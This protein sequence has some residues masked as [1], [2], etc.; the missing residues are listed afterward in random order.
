MSDKIELRVI[1][2]KN[3]RL[4]GADMEWIG[5]EVQCCERCGAEHVGLYS[6]VGDDENHMYCGDCSVLEWGENVP[7]LEEIEIKR[8][9]TVRILLGEYRGQTGWVMFASEKRN[10]VHVAID[11]VGFAFALEDVEKV[12]EG[13]DDE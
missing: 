5:A 9:D 3:G 4:S 10:V 8:Q 12:A 7:E 13:D 1:T 11:N 6:F 2:P